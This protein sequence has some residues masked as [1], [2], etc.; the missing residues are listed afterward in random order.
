MSAVLDNSQV[1]PMAHAS[2][3]PG[4]G[5]LFRRYTAPR[6]IVAPVSSTGVSTSPSTKKP[7]MA[8]NSGV[9]NV[10]LDSAVRLPLEALKKNTPYDA[11]DPSRE[12]YRSSSAS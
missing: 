6:V 12:M 8:A 10:R 11:A 3:L 7:V 5:F 1:L 9:R 4:E 2:S